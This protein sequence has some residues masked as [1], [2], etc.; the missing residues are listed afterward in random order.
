MKSRSYF[1]DLI[2]KRANFKKSM[3]SME[4]QKKNSTINNPTS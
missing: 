1:F 4:N 2:Q 3:I